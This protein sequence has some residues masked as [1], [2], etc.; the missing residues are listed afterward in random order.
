MTTSSP[1]DATTVAVT[2]GFSFN[3]FG[4]AATELTISTNGWL[5]LET[6]YAGTSYAYNS[7][8]PTASVPNALLAPGWDDLTNVQI[9][10]YVEGDKVTVQWVG[11]QYFAPYHDFQMQAVLHAD[12]TIDFIYGA[13]HE[14]D[15]LSASVG[16]ENGT[17]TDGVEIGYNTAGSMAAESSYTLVPNL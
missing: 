9:C 13:D 12:D 7:T 6:D 4:D 1:D 11:N 17:G 5:T 15:G 10:V 8:L 2:L 16:I 14:D 3:L